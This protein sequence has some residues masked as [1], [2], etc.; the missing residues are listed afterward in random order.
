MM[1]TVMKTE[2]ETELCTI[3]GADGGGELLTPEEHDAGGEPLQVP[4]R[5][6]L[7]HLNNNKVVPEG[8]LC[9]TCIRRTVDAYEFSSSLSARNTPPLSEKIRALRRKLYELTQKIDVFIVV[10]GPGANAG[11]TYSEED[12][13][14][15]EKDALAAAAAADDEDLERARNARGE[16]VY[17]C[18]VC[19]QSFQRVT[20]FRSHVSQHPADALHSCWSCGAQFSSL[21]ALRAHHA[22]HAPLHELTCHLCSTDFATAAELRAH[23][24]SGAACGVCPACGARAAS[25]AALAAH[26]A[27]AHGG[28]GAG[29]G[30]GGGGGGAPC[31]CAR[32]FRTLPAPAALAAHLLRHRRPDRFLCGYDACILRFSSR[33]HLLAHIRKCHSSS[34]SAPAPPAAPAAAAPTCEHCG[35]KFGSV[36]AMKRHARV[37]RDRLITKED[38]Q[39]SQLEGDGEE[40]EVEANVNVDAEGEVEYLEVETLEDMEYRE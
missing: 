18:S 1:A 16:N 10:G 26:V 29:G 32:C 20:E 40:M 14:M 25:R 33:G 19:P 27:A 3:C 6:M 15:V 24:A 31:V 28:G 8:R 4:L 23:C 21:A 39:D 17:Q 12:I 37:H 38:G 2:S 5:T 22:D 34:G 36:A 11:G 30:G 35:R 7:L 13:I 9:P